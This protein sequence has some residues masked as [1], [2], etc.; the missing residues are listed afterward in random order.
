MRSNL[1]GYPSWVADLFSASLAINL[2]SLALPLVLI[3]VYDRIIP[4][5]SLPTLGVLV[6]GCVVAIILEN[7]LRLVRSYISGWMATRFEHLAGCEAVDKILDAP[8]PI[9]ERHGVG[10]HL[11]RLQALDTLRSLYGGQ[12]FQI[13]LD[14]P[15]VLLYLLVIGIL[16]GRLLLAC[17]VVLILFGVFFHVFRRNFARYRSEQVAINDRRYNFLI[18]MLSGIH[19]VKSQ[20]MEEQMLRRYERLQATAAESNMNVSLWS[21][22]P[23]NAGAFFSQVMTFAM[24]GAGGESV[25][26]GTM[27][28]GVLTAATTLG[29]RVMQPIQQAAGYWLR[30]SDAEIARK[31]VAELAALPTETPS[32]ALPFPPD[33]RGALRLNQVSFQ[34]RED[35]P[36][37]IAGVNLEVPPMAMVGIRCMGSMGMTTLSF[38]MMGILKPTSGS[39]FLDDYDLAAWDHRQLQ[40]RI[41]YLP[42]YGVLFT[43]TILDNLCMFNPKLRAAALDAAAL[44]DL[45]EQIAALPR[46][47]ETEITAQSAANLPMGLVQ[48]I[49]LTRA[50]VVRPRV[51]VFDK[52]NASLDQDSLEVFMKFFLRMKGRATLVLF[53]DNFALLEACDQRYT[54]HNG[55]LIPE[56]LES[57]ALVGERR[58]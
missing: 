28:L 1:P 33:I 21:A 58:P 31:Q 2:L 57:S 8:L 45:D 32:D 3:Q 40:G 38:L 20:A 52:A 54:L 44:F 41:E 9:F 55:T 26:N 17:F 30:L 19:L 6:G 34:Y 14:V 56:P 36:F 35:A 43:G 4:N 25:M 13:F 16:D 47:Y 27:T 11:E 49:A 24:I 12:I 50:F 10:V 18:E 48:H 53:T 22:L 15:F 42:Q 51:I 7:L 37:V 5:A 29:G 23:V 39:V 46:G